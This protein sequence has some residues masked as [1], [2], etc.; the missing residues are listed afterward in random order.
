VNCEVMKVC[1]LLTLM[2]PLGQVRLSNVY[3]MHFFWE[4]HSSISSIDAGQY[5]VFM[6]FQVQQ[7]CPLTRAGM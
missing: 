4:V 1:D 7:M 6:K 3:I 2:D 5:K